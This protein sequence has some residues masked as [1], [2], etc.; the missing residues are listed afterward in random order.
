MQEIDSVALPEN[1]C[2]I[3][4]PESVKDFATLQVGLLGGRAAPLGGRLLPTGGC[5][6]QRSQGG[7]F[8]ASRP[9]LNNPRA[10]AARG[11]RCK[12]RRQPHCSVLLPP[13]KVDEIQKNIASRRNRIFLLMEEVRGSEAGVCV[14]WGVGWGGGTRAWGT[15]GRG[16]GQ[17]GRRDEREAPWALARKA[18]VQ[19]HP[20]G[21]GTRQRLL[22]SRGRSPPLAAAERTPACPAPWPQVRRLRIQ[23]RLKGV[24][25]DKEDILAQVGGGVVG[26][27]GAAVA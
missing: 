25:E 24:T 3:E 6:A 8:E 18:G 15:A 13:L 2:I 23:L 9:G 17:P 7:P 21:V 1:F 22:R 4:S 26:R 19:G 20:R 14:A 27:V 5:L 10:G 16:S 12:L 11:R